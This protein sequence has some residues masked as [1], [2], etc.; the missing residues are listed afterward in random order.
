M[1]KGFSF[2]GGQRVPATWK[3]VENRFDCLENILQE[4]LMVFPDCQLDAHPKF[5][6]ANFLPLN[7]S[8]H[9]LLRGMQV[10]IY[11]FRYMC[12]CV[13]V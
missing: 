1:E 2:I 5:L 7:L 8:R 6:N 11:F 3:E 9:M 13:H 12:A 10:G 4:Y